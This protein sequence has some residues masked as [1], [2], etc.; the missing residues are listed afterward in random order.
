MKQ[1]TFQYVK[2]LIEDSLT[3]IAPEG[4]IKNP[5]LFSNTIRNN[6]D[7]RRYKVKW[8]ASTGDSIVVKYAGFKLFCYY[9]YKTKCW[10]TQNITIE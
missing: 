9:D 6:S 8:Y 10:Q 1:Y 2:K 3:E 4:T 5:I 7:D